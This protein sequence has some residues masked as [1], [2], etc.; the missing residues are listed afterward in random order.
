MMRSLWKA[1]WQL[2][3]PFHAESLWDP[4]A[5]VRGEHS[6]RKKTCPHLFRVVLNSQK[7]ETP[8]VALGGRMADRKAL[9]RH[10]G[11]VLSREKEGCSGR[12]C[13][14]DEP[15]EQARGRRRYKVCRAGKS[16]ETGRRRVTA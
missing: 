11:I 7:V 4:A 2:L 16:T 3:K 1:T 10:D 8:H 13:R 12:G 5:P 9:S 15:G 14:E 6:R